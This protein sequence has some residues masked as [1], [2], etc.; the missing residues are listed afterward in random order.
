MSE[1]TDVTI[2]SPP[3]VDFKV[4]TADGVAV[5]GIG[6]LWND[7][8][9]FVRFTITKLVPGLTEVDPDTWVAYTRDEGEPDY[10][11]G[12]SLVDHGDG[13]YTFTFNTDVAAVTD[14]TYEP[15]LTHRV[16]GQMGS[17]SFPSLEQNLYYDFIPATGEMT[18]GKK[19]ATMESCNECH[20]DLVFH[21]RRFLVE[22]CVQCHNPDLA[23]NTAGVS[24]GDMAFMTHKIHA[25]GTFEVL[26]DQEW[27]DHV[28][29]IGYPQEL[30]NCTK[31]HNGADEATPDGGNWQSKQTGNTCFNSCHGVPETVTASFH[32][33]D[34]T[35]SACHTADGIGGALD[36]ASFHIT[37]NATENNPQLLSGQRKIDY[38]LSFVSVDATG[39]ATVDFTIFSDD[40]PLDLTNLP[41]DLAAPGRYPG[42]LLAYALPQGDT[43]NPADYNNLGQEDAQP[44]SVGIDDVIA[45]GNLSCET[46]SGV[47]TAVLADNPF[48][49][50]AT[51][52]TVGLQGY[53]QQD[54]DG[55]GEDD[56]SL[57]TQS[58][59][60]TAAGDISRRDVVSSAACADCHEI[61]EGH[62]G[63]RNFTA[64]G[65]VAICTLCHVPN[66]S[67]G[68]R[69]VDISFP[70]DTNNLKELI[71]GI[72][73]AAK[74]EVPMEFVRNRGGA[75]LYAFLS[76]DNFMDYMAPE[77][78][79]VQESAHVVTYPGILSDCTNCHG[80]SGYELPLPMG[81]LMSNVRTGGTLADV[82][83]DGVVDEADYSLL[84][85]GTQLPNDSDWVNSPTASACFY[86]HD[87]ETTR[88]HMEQ[89]GAELSLP[90]FMGVTRAEYAPAESCV[91]CHGPGG[92]ADVNVVHGLE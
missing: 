59:V 76:P 9:R 20:D 68:G 50:D 3:V 6:N 1:I 4:E 33:E 51:M 43:A 83:E 37:P 66:L 36:N 72:H 7:S 55:D 63:N 80:D 49:A 90:N 48:P 60:M 19:V 44:I 38:E 65:G 32:N 61:F 8:N 45:A 15:N 2:A 82:N 31:C 18:V 30:A 12:S 81:A 25:A 41:T 52:R 67:S 28:T 11:T 64:D 39:V 35:C 77:G 92:S 53:F 16:A 5:T 74:R 34:A 58:V 29:H 17:G 46:A 87:S 13:T 86:C 47:C 42:F 69:D 10:D 88:L 75:R 78:S 91:V 14:V 62:G 84:R 40:V 79:F 56:V 24:E 71:H 26:E 27:R 57:H 70:E 22:Y 21:G 23:V 54:L 73:G 89:N 85:E